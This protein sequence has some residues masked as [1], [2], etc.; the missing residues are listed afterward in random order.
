MIY[1]LFIS[2]I[3]SQD[4]MVD[5]WIPSNCEPI[6]I[7]IKELLSLK[8]NYFTDLDKFPLNLF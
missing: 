8:S 5:D 4:L 2:L 7:T 1:F 6:M 3:L